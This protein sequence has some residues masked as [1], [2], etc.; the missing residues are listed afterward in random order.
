MRIFAWTLFLAS[1][2]FVAFL[3]MK[4][5]QG[6]V[7]D[8]VALLSRAEWLM[9]G[10]EQDLEAALED[11]NYALRSAE[12]EP[13]KY[14]EVMGR[15]LAARGALHRDLGLLVK[16]RTDLE[17]VLEVYRSDDVRV[18]RRGARDL[19]QRTRPTLPLD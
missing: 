8:P 5:R 16:A 10:P 1:G 6:T 4:V 18:K 2:A 13:E 9:T 3:V 17:T 14:H 19:P 7:G 11:L 12:A 15:V